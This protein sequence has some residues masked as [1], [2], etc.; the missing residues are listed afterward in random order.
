MPGVH[1]RLWGWWGAQ[2]SVVG[3]DNDGAYRFNML[4]PGTYLVE[5]IAP[6]F[7]IFETPD[8]V[9]VTVS[10]NIVVTADFGL[11]PWDRHYMPMLVKQRRV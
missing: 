3:T 1:L 6:D 5:A 11:Q 2:I 10:S 7:Y 8:E 4:V 9:E